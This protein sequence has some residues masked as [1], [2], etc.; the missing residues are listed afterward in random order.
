MRPLGESLIFVAL[1][2]LRRCLGP[3]GRVF[4]IGNR[5][6]P[7]PTVDIKDPYVVQYGTDLH[8][9][10]LYDGSEYLVIKVMYEPDESVLSWRRRLAGEDRSNTLV[11]L[12][13]H[14]LG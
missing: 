12:R 9:R 13:R 6:D 7:T 5:N 11:H 3:G 4:L 14:A 10:R 1:G 2:Y 8:L